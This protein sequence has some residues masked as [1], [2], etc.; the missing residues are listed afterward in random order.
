[1]D[2]APFHKSLY[3]KNAIEN[4]GHQL[5]YMP[6]YSPHLNPIEKKWAHS[7]YLKRKHQLSVQQV[8]YHFI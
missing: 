8:F 2:N 4:F 3:I 6:T 1:M 7:K 5:L